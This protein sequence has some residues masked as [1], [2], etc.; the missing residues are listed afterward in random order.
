MICSAVLY[1][2]RVPFIVMAFCVVWCGVVWCG[3]E[4]GEER[5]H[6][7]ERRGCMH[8]ALSCVHVCDHLLNREAMLAASLS[9]RRGGTA[10]RVRGGTVCR[11]RGG[12]AC[13]VHVGRHACSSLPLTR[14]AHTLAAAGRLRQRFY[15]RCILCR[16]RNA[17]RGCSFAT[18]RRV[19]L[20]CGLLRLCCSRLPTGSSRRCTSRRDIL[21]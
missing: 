1:Y 20:R 4:M 18:G 9:R 3:G 7:L 10:C 13:R 19:R 16:E 2:C 21:L 11:I 8:A 17:F 6:M 12:T 15:W 14:P 5:K